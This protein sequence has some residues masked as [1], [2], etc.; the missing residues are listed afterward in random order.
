MTK[1]SVLLRSQSI[2]LNLSQFLQTSGDGYD[3]SSSSSN[4]SKGS[5]PD[6]VLPGSE[7]EYSK[8]SG[9]ESSK[10]NTKSSYREQV[11]QLALT[12]P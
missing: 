9:W 7:T 2:Q 5:L 10:D 6:L 3:S 11:L 12:F 4:D 8:Y 1:I